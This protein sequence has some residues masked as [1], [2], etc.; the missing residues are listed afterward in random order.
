[1]DN[2]ECIYSP[3]KRRGPIPGR[4]SGTTRKADVALN[5]NGSSMSD[6]NSIGGGGGN[7]GLTANGTTSSEGGGGGSSSWMQPQPA[8][9]SSGGMMDPQIA[10]FLA[11]Q[12]QQQ[13]QQQ[14]N[15]TDTM[16]LSI[17]SG[18]PA[19][20]ILQQQ[21]Q[22][23]QQQIQ[24]QQAGMA[25]TTDGTEER[26]SRRLKPG[27]EANSNNNTHSNGVPSTIMNHTHLLDRNDPE[28][29]RLR[30]FYKLSIDELFCLPATPTDEEYCAR[31]N[32]NMISSSS[33]NNNGT[34]SS[35]NTILTPS[36]IPGTHLAA[37][38]AAR[39]A[40][41]ALGAIV[42]NEV[43]LAMELCNAVVH[44]LRESV[45]EPVQT[46]VIYEVAKAY[47]LLGVFR[48]FRG[49]MPRYFKYR[50]VCMTYLSKLEVRFCAE[51]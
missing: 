12:Q 47:F 26:M 24:Q 42:H 25:D 23:L 18:S 14:Q 16:D 13:Q 48:A 34:N 22:L 27:E 11:Q 41:A 30:A 5:H 36:M 39:F 45:S 9:G 37:L 51:L 8:V 31:L 46:P 28:G 10:A 29:S 35:S 7:G 21:I 40:E 32:N 15:N 3:A 44:C 43:S 38:S 33:G 2:F 17:G 50:R 19:V 20:N 1:M 4:T 49:D 6:S